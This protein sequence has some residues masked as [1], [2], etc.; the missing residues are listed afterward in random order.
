MTRQTHDLSPFDHIVNLV[1]E[2]GTDG[3]ADAFTLLLN[4]A[5]KVERSRA[6][7]AAP[8]E[9]TDSRKGHAN[10]FK[11]KTHNSR[12]GRLTVAVPQVRGE[13]DFYP[14]ALER[15]VRSERA[16]TLAIAEP[17]EVR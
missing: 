14:S 15:G 8:Y 2:N 17:S 4:E 13:V 11:S 7:D 16:L 5:M 1:L 6:L 12:F 3:L 9:R 10:G